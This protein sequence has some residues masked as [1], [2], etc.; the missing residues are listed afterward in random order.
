LVQA[1]ADINAQNSISGETAIHITIR[2]QSV[3]KLKKLL[4]LRANV[5]IA[6]ADR[7][8]PLMRAIQQSEQHNSSIA[9]VHVLLEYGANFADCIIAGSE[10]LSTNRS[11]IELVNE[12]AQRVRIEAEAAR[13]QVLM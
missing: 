2:A 4:S 13:R 10:L 1:G 11:L 3:C 9:I 5:N 7:R 6:D 8:T 12:H